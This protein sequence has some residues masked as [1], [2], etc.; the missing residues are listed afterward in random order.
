MLREIRCIMNEIPHEKGHKQSMGVSIHG[1]YRSLYFNSGF[2]NKD[3][4]EK[5]TNVAVV[6]ETNKL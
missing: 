6:K 1:F 4:L 5:Y 3:N 2:D